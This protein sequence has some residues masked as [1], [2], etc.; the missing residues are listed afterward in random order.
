MTGVRFPVEAIHFLFPT[1]SIPTLELIQPAIRW[2]P[3]ALS[4]GVKRQELEADHSSPS[5]TEVKNGEAKLPFPHMPFFDCA[6]LY[7]LGQGITLPLT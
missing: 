1:Y 4:P 6:Q 3:G 7:N 2:T 5:S